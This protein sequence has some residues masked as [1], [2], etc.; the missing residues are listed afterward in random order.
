MSAKKIGKWITHL[1]SL[2]CAAKG[3]DLSAE[4][5]NSQIQRAHAT[6]Y[7]ELRRMDEVNE[8]LLSALELAVEQL[9]SLS[10]EITSGYDGDTELIETMRFAIARARASTEI[11]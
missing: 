9:D 6:L 8:C 5:Q 11:G 3:R 7:N 4:E 1:G 2:V 10:G